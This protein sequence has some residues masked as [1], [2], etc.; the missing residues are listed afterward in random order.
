MG[1]AEAGGAEVLGWR[2]MTGIEAAKERNKARLVC[3]GAPQSQQS[4]PRGCPEG[5]KCRHQSQ[6]PCQPG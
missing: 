4:T 2:T 3:R 1:G 5:R 6:R